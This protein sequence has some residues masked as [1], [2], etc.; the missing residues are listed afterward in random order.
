MPVRFLFSR[1]LCSPILL[2]LVVCIN[3]AIASETYFAAPYVQGFLDINVEKPL[4][5]F[6]TKEN[7]PAIAPKETLKILVWNIYKAELF[8]E[9]P[10]PFSLQSYD[11]SIIQEETKDNLLKQMQK[12]GFSYFLPSFSTGKM[13]TGLSTYSRYLATAT[14]GFHTDYSEPFIITPKGVL[15]TDFGTLRVI[16]V[17]S[18]NFVPFEEWKYELDKVLKVTKEKNWVILAGDFNAWNE[19]RTDY[20]KSQIKEN[21]LQEVTFKSKVKRTNVLGY[22][23]DFV[24]AKGFKLR[25]SQI[26]PMNDY[27]DH[28]ALEVTVQKIE[29]N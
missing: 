10:L 19:E 9:R 22:P 14:S 5:N 3:S 20:L 15:I 21:G 8:K 29:S 23:L 1:V 6:I 24:F 7:P 4:V 12:A 11:F 28:H 27:S 13:T 17:H 25:D 18:L 16:N 26:I 2:F